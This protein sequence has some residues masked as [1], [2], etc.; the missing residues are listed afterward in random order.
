VDP[1][2]HITSTALAASVFVQEEKQKWPMI[3]AAVAAGVA[4]DL[5][6]LS[7][8]WGSTYYVRYHQTLTHNLFGAPLLILA[9]AY[10]FW[11]F[12]SYRNF[13]A[14]CGLAAL[15]GFGH[16]LLDLTIT[17]G[18]APF[19]PFSSRTYCLNLILLTDPLF[20]LLCAGACYA[21]FRLSYWHLRRK[22]A[23]VIFAL[24]SVYF[25]ARYLFLSLR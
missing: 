22:F 18:L 11:R 23:A 24:L 4:P 20:L 8:L 9:V 25:V 10:M 6:A 13:P 16:L 19:W 1:L 2:S 17:W 21:I 3:G 14:L 5:D 12:S 7:L 15:G